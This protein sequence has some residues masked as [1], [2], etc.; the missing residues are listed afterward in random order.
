MLQRKFSVAAAS[1]AAS[2]VCACAT[3]IALLAACGQKGPLR[4]PEPATGTAAPASSA[5]SAARP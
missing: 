4:L 5:A 2:R 3:A 1:K